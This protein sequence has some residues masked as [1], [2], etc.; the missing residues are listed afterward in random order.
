MAVRILLAIA[1]ASLLAEPVAGVTIDPSL[2][3]RRRARIKREG[4]LV[5]ALHFAG[6][7]AFEP[8]ELKQYMKTTE[9]NFLRIAFFDR[10]VLDK[11]LA[12]IERFYQSRGFIDAQV[13][14][15]DVQLS[16]DGLEIEVLIGVYEG[17]SWIVSDVAF[18]GNEV[19]SDEE[20]R[21]VVT[22][23]P[24][25][26]YLPN[27]V[28]ADRRRLLDAYARNSYLDA[29]VL[30]SIDR[31]DASQLAEIRYRIVEG[32]QAVIDSIRI[33]GDDKTREFV[34][35]RE[36]E[37]SAGEPFDFQKIGES[38]A[39]LYRTG[40]FNSVWIEPAP[41]DTGKTAKRLD[42]RVRERPSG[43]LDFKAGYAAIDG[44]EAGAE[45]VNRSVQGQAIEL[46]LSGTYGERVREA[47]LSVGD[48]WFT[49]RPIGIDAFTT[50]AW[51][52]EVSYVAEALG[53][54]FVLS[55]RFGRALTVDGGYGFERTIVL[56]A[57]EDSDEEGTNYT[58]D[59][60]SA[61]TYDTRSDILDAR[62]GML[63]RAKVRFASSRLG[64]TNDFSQYELMW[65]GFKDIRHGRTAGLAVRLGWI[66]PQGTGGVPLNEFYFAGGEGSIRGFGRNSLSPLG[67]DAEPMGG[68]A[69]VEIQAE[70]RFPVYRR[71][72]AA[73]FVDAG[74]AF[75]D[76]YAITRDGLAAAAGGGLRFRTDFGLLRLD[77]GTP[78]SE[79]GPPQLY[80][81][82][83]QAF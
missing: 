7:D 6:N 18:D 33:S 79:S 40:L 53:A 67:D 42:V 51:N 9:S 14:L 47:R 52:D 60:F 32:G 38:Q 44:V 27:E 28:E 75:E 3:K 61:V 8:H 15:E 4:P 83:G 82:V 73:V 80:F 36:L 23:K 68:R 25:D 21:S 2:V 16:A 65:R 72:G 29:T 46:G 77:F 13:A 62:R 56:E 37:F 24:D 49:G 57:V 12:N 58:S 78:I 34:I 74:Q 26:P 1:A 45:F 59:L 81:G 55:K 20:L 22:L 76:F 35:R 48:P 41:E 19:F 70:V 5:E 43:L 30:Q 71:L 66:R 17:P 63:A 69:L 54:G 39:R 50:Y 31:N 10:K 64:G 11:D